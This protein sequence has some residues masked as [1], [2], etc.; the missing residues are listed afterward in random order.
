M[1]EEY[2]GRKR[3]AP[4][5]RGD[6]PTIEAGAEFHVASLLWYAG[7]DPGRPGLKETPKRFVKALEEYTAGYEM[8][9]AQILKVFEDGAQGADEMVIVRDI[10]FYSL[11]EHHMAPFFGT[12]DIGY[13]PNGKIVGLSKLARLTEVF[14]R[15]LQVQERMTNQIA[16]SLFQILE[17]KGVGVRVYARHLCMEARGVRCQGANTM[18]TALRGEL[19]DSLPARTEFL[20][21]VRK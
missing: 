8:D 12:V 10:P 13:I 3:V 15:R 4:P 2:T 19:Y 18:T 16:D 20:D 6:N 21:A 17:C 9:P 1:Y 14:S 11:C 5:T 7:E